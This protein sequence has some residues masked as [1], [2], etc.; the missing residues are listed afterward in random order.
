[1]RRLDGVGVT[2]VRARGRGLDRAVSDPIV[3]RGGTT[4]A[5]RHLL[6]HQ[7]TARALGGEVTR[8]EVGWGVGGRSF[9]VVAP[10]PWMDDGDRFTLLMS[11]RT[12]SPASPTAPRSSPRRRT[13]RSGP[14]PTGSVTTCSACRATPSS[15]PT[16]RS[17]RWRHDGRSSATQW[18]TPAS[19][20]SAR[21][22]P[23][24]QDRVAGWISEF[25]RRA[26]GRWRGS[27]RWPTLRSTRS[28]PSRSAT[29]SS[30]AGRRRT[31]SSP[32]R[33]GCRRL[34][35]RQRVQRLLEHGVMQIVAVTDPLQLGLHRG[36]R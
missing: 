3:H 29:S 20:R 14:K 28:T 33:S 25:Y 4:P 31:P 6:R 19:P 13:A 34:R 12:R 24:D 16:C 18:S 8:A 15:S 7:L 11:H 23:V 22:L 2:P 17:H 35:V 21:Q 36:R 5:G 1:M 9:D 32:A 27:L 30:T 10:A 26:L